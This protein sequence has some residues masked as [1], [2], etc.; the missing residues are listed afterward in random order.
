[1]CFRARSLGASSGSSGHTCLDAFFGGDE[2]AV[3]EL[4]LEVGDLRF[5][6]VFGVSLVSSEDI[7]PC[8]PLSLSLRLLVSTLENKLE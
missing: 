8:D 5:L 2:E 4:S 1:M 7:F 3:T 6:V